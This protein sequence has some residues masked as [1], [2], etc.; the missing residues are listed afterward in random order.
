MRIRGADA[1]VKIVG[2]AAPAVNRG[3]GCWA[4]LKLVG[5]PHHFQLIGP[6]SK[7]WNDDSVIYGLLLR[8]EIFVSVIDGFEG[9]AVGRCSL[10]QIAFLNKVLNC[11]IKVKINVTVPSHFAPSP[12]PLRRCKR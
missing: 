3:R 2:Q 10:F 6:A 8:R 5:V 9:N 7:R 4:S 1:P 11:F 12:Y